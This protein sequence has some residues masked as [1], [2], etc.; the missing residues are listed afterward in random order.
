MPVANWNETIIDGKRYLVIDVAKFRIPLDWDPS[1]NM[2]IAVAAPDGGLGNFPALV[3]G[4]DG[5]PPELDNVI[6]FTPLEYDDPTPEFAS[7]T[8]TAPNVYK[9]NL[10]LKRGRQGP[11]GTMT[12]LGAS[13]LTG[14]PAAKK[15]FVINATGDGVE[16]VAQKVGN[17]YR[18]ASIEPTPSGNPAWTLCPIGI[19]P[20]PF[21]CLVRVEGQCIVTPTGADFRGDLIARL[22]TTGIVN[23]ETAGPEV[24]RGFGLAGAAPPPLIFS[25][26]RP[27]GESASYG[28]I[29][30]GNAATIYVR[31][32]RQSGNQTFIT[33]PDTCRFE[34]ITEPLL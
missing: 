34:A 29:P 6:N 10:G 24:A 14:T 4:D 32:E 31:V 3:R 19:E 1:S 20:Q 16:I 23:G 25:S 17:R 2:F 12:I 21:D 22:S 18:P 13:D 11:P 7:F 33:A 26:A 28:M 5:L 27:F 9:L 30:Q 8:E 15:M